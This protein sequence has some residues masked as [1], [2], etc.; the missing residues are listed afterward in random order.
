MIPAIL[1]GGAKHWKLIGIALLMAALA[2][3]SARVSNLKGHLRDA[4]AALI[5]PVTKKPWQF[6][7]MRDAR[8]LQ[9]CRGSVQALE[10]SRQAQNA[11]V[12][13]LEA[14]STRRVTE[15]EKALSAARR[16]L[17][18]AEADARR[19]LRPPVGIDACART[20]EIDRRLLETLQ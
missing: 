9:T 6:E 1:A 14:E 17:A 12:A 7:A 16:G 15:A 20:E 8:D 2:I 5:N 10:A 18:K 19:M 4:R 13:A 11:A 3:Q